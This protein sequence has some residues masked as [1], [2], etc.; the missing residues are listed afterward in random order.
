L[1]ETEIHKIKRE[2]TEISFLSEYL[3]Q[4]QDKERISQS[5]SYTKYLLQTL[6]SDNISIAGEDI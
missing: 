2:T 6:Y 4:L 3:L 5:S 1:N